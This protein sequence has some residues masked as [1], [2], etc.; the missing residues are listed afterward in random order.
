MKKLLI[1]AIIAFAAWQAKLHY[2]DLIHPHPEHE[3]VIENGSGRNIERLR[4]TVGG[5]TF[6]KERLPSEEKAVFHFNVNKDADFN[7]TWQ[8][9]NS[10]EEKSWNGGMVPRGPMVQRHFINIEDDGSVIY[11]VRSLGG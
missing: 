9:E 1:L 2:A 4:L 3:A 8:W 6:V 10:M 5:Q 7:V 11:T